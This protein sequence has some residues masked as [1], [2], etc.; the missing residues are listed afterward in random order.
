MLP[1]STAILL[2]EHGMHLR[3]RSFAVYVPG[4]HGTQES[5]DFQYVPSGQ[6]AQASPALKVPA[7]QLN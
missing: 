2:P 7:E 6:G 5:L 4:L 3:E 1:A